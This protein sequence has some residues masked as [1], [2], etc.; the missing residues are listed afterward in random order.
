MALI[1]PLSERY[2]FSIRNIQ[3]YLREHWQ[4]NFSIGEISQAQAKATAA[5]AEPYRQ[6][7]EYVR[8]QP[9]AHADETRHFRGTECRW[10]WALVTLQACY[11][12]TQFSRGKEAADTLLGDF[13]RLPGHR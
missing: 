12:L 2:H 7:G 1:A 6:I 11:F 13:F 4:L 5:L 9:V 10:L 3:D 8:Q